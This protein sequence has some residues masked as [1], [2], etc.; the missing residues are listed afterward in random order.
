M[1][2]YH[3]SIYFSLPFAL[4]EWLCVNWN[5]DVCERS[6]ILYAQRE[7]QENKTS[8]FLIH[9]TFT[10]IYINVHI[11][12]ILF[13]TIF[14]RGFSNLIPTPRCYPTGAH[15]KPSYTSNHRICQIILQRKPK[16]RSLPKKESGVIS[17]KKKRELRRIRKGAEFGQLQDVV[18]EE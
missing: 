16:W 4:H 2:I 13:R 5:F 10:A 3:C 7:R 11:R 8:C 17:G 12:P 14:P 15:H 1:R 9:F 18:K 6:C